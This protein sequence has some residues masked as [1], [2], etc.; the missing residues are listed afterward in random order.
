V[1]W[2]R[3]A[4]F[5]CMSVFDLNSYDY[6][7]PERLIANVP[8]GRRDESRL[9]V[10]NKKGRVLAQTYFGRIID[11][12]NENWVLVLNN[13]KVF[14]ARLTV[15]KKGKGSMMEM[16]VVR[17]LLPGYWE[18]MC[19]RAKKV[20]VGDVYT[21]VSG[22][23]AVE[24]RVVDRL[25]EG[26][27]L[28][29]V[30]LSRRD[31]LQVLQSVGVVPLPTY[32]EKQPEV[33]YQS[34]YQT[35]FAKSVGSVAAPTAGL[36]FTP[37]L[38]S[39]LRNQGVS[40]EE[41]T[42]HVGPGTFAP[43]RGEDIREHRMHEEK[44][45]IDVNVVARLNEHKRV[46]KKIMAVGTTATRWL[47]SLAD[48]GWLRSIEGEWMT[49]LFIYPGYKFKFV[50][51]IVTNFHLP[52]STLLMLVAAFLGENEIGI[53]RLQQIYKLAMDGDY[54]FYSFGDAMM[55]CPD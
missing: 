53:E 20:K 19:K 26:L 14:N 39:E 30:D 1:G 5:F 18:V 7:L 21:F 33:D 54:R 52:K 9:L 2:W 45:E 28:M 42:L 49:D 31:F 34:L 12:L 11:W 51:G 22:D 13:T 6:D 8:V 32:I 46:G 16:L 37:K 29:Q 4:P 40:I 55:I 41:I 25:E 47:E 50:D 43:V 23:Q 44:M 38:L 24:M 15:V 27:R 17:E 3:F 36:H 10:A 48:D 35:V